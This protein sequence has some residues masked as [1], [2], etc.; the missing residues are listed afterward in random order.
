[1]LGAYNV[2]LKTKLKA[3]FFKA[4][5]I[6]R[7]Y[8]AITFLHKSPKYLHSDSEHITANPSITRFPKSKKE[9]VPSVN[10]SKRA[11]NYRKSLAGSLRM[12]YT[13]PKLISGTPISSTYVKNVCN[14][15]YLGGMSTSNPTSAL[16]QL[17]WG[18]NNWCYLECLYCKLRYV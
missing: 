13:V 4:F 6:L 18:K 16:L 3:E 1:M 17:H 10:S 2:N 14:P 12:Q 7:D 8:T 11:S 15:L 9:T 5:F